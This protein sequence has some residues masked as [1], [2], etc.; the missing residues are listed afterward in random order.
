MKSEMNI[1]AL[2]NFLIEKGNYIAPYRVATL[3]EKLPYTPVPPE[4]MLTHWDT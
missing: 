1:V 4:L 3:R 2:P